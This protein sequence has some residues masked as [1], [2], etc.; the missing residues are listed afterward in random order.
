MKNLY[1]LSYSG[2]K[3]TRKINAH[4]YNKLK[5][6]ERVDDYLSAKKNVIDNTY[7]NVMGCSKTLCNKFIQI[8]ENSN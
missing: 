5:Y 7:S 8:T 1:F 6:F 2:L 3:D 4:A